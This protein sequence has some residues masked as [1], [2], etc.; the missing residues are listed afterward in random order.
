MECER[1]GRYRP[2]QEVMPMRGADGG[3]QMVC[4]RCRRLT[5]HRPGSAT[6]GPGLTLGATTAGQ[7]PA[8]SR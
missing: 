2:S 6:R 3:Q 8:R 5:G 7:T 4:A 1:C